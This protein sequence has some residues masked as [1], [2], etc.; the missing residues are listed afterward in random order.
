[1]K[2]LGMP[3]LNPSPGLI[4]GRMVNK[5]KFETIELLMSQYFD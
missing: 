2:P 5:I 4:K 1:M 3:C